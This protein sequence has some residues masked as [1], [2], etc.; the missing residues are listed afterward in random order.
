MKEIII[1]DTEF[2]AW[3]GSQERNWSGEG[4][5]KEIIQIGAVKVSLD[6]LAVEETLNINIKPTL[7]PELSDYIKALTGI[8]QEDVDNGLSLPAA[9][10]KFLNF[11]GGNAVFSWGNDIDVINEDLILKELESISPEKFFDLR[12]WLVPRYPELGEANSGSLA[13][14]M[15]LDNQISGKEHD[16]VYDCL[17]QQV[18]LASDLK[19]QKDKADFCANFN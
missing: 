6:T 19:T 14:L 11:S 18:V 15:G 7:N 1:F 3:K 16:A 4:E 12:A 17:S 5:Y 8:S 2:T 10:L 13:R 9:V